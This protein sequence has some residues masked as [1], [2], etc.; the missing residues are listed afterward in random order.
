MRCIDLAQILAQT[1]EANQA[2]AEKFNVRVVNTSLI[3]EVFI[4]VD[5]DRLTQV[6]TNLISNAIKFSNPQDIVF[7]ETT[8]SEKQLKLL[9]RDSGL[10]FLRVFRQDI[11]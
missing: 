8:L 3:D 2:Y 4:F 11:Y 7:I 6:L 1:V 5:P 9:L 10:V